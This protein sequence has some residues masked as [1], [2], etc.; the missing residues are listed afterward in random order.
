MTVN[1]KTT[2]AM[3]P[4][5][6]RVTR[7]AGAPT[8]RPVVFAGQETIRKHRRARNDPRPART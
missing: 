7:E 4:I 8:L 1:L 2:A 5:E 3:R 6:V